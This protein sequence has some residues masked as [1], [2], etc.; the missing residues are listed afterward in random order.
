M[1][2]S[3]LSTT[4]YDG[5]SSSYDISRQF[6]GKTPKTRKLPPVGSSKF[7]N[8]KSI[9]RNVVAAVWEGRGTDKGLVGMAWAEEEG[10]EWTFTEFRDSGA[11]AI[12]SAMLQLCE[13][14]EIVIAETQ[15]DRANNLLFSEVIK[16]IT[17]TA[18]ITSVQRR[19]F[20]PE[21]GLAIM[22]LLSSKAENLK[23]VVGK[24]FACAAMGALIRFVEFR[25]EFVLSAQ[26]IPF[27]FFDVTRQCLMDHAS[28]KNLEVINDYY[29][30]KERRTLLAVIDNTITALGYRILRANLLQPSTDVAF[31]NLRLDAISELIENPMNLD[32]ESLTAMERALSTTLDSAVLDCKR[33]SISI[34]QQKL[35]AIKTGVQARIDATRELY[36]QR[37]TQ[38][39]ELSNEEME[40]HLPGQN[41]RLAVKLLRLN[42]RLTVTEDEL[43]STTGL[44]VRELIAYLRP[45]V[46]ALYSLI[47]DV[48]LLDMLQSMAVYATQTHACRP[49][50]GQDVVILKGRHPILD[51]HYSD[52]VIPNDMY[53]TPDNR[54]AVITGPNMAGKSTLLKMLCQFSLLAQL[55]SYVPATMCK[56]PVFKR[57]F[58]RMDHNDSLMQNLSSF[59]LEMRDVATIL[60]FTDKDCLIVM[61]ELAR[62]TATEEGVAISYAISEEL[63]KKKS[64]VMLAT[65]YLDL[66]ALDVAS[67]AVINM[68]FKSTEDEKYGGEE[69]RHRLFKGP[70]KGPLYGFDVIQLANFPPDLVDEAEDL[71]YRLRAET[72]QRRVLDQQTLKW[73]A[74]TR[75]G[76]RLKVA[77][78]LLRGHPLSAQLEYL[79]ALS[80]T[81]RDDLEETNA[82]GA[83][84][85]V[86]IQQALEFA[87]EQDTE[88]GADEV[89]TLLRAFEYALLAEEVE[90]APQVHVSPSASQ[91]THQEEGSATDDT[92]ACGAN[93]PPEPTPTFPM[94]SVSSGED[95]FLSMEPQVGS[96]ARN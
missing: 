65:H 48:C 94:I 85:D 49:E 13:P 29:P 39:E 93:E 57:I 92:G 80:G 10:V 3:Q 66:A 56:L 58:T 78:S 79:T 61:D 64:Y 42:D 91:R 89:E 69:V 51:L 7:L 14:E 50:F 53:M 87:N 68:H 71:A 4:G 88:L 15:G 28:W 27:K 30:R 83:Q 84:D 52:T 76:H 36:M 23:D 19:F 72:E 70:Y 43:L 2:S 46:G 75:I 67:S 47:D 32:S 31:I 44:R 38:I 54:F 11:Y 37:L 59:G 95:L 60:E 63:I 86:E 34:I 45:L 73:R 74:L 25:N 82:A 41:C 24:Q 90:E 62:S 33:S 16:R 21:R 5:G 8:S 12:L 40:Q 20:N 18:E 9:E 26:T 6:L 35:F 77:I 81:L 1:L 22:K 17:P 55:G 96:A